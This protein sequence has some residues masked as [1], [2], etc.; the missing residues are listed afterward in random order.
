MIYRVIGVRSG[1]SPDRFQIVFTEFT[2]TGGKWNYD[3]V[4]EQQFTH[5]QHWKEQLKSAGDISVLAYQL[6][7]I[8]YGKYI[9]EKINL[10]IREHALEHKV[11]LVASDGYTVFNLPAQGLSAEIGHCKEMFPGGRRDV[12]GRI[13]NCTDGCTQVARRS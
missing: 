3:N 1:H 2:E 9:G 4:I 13:C 10:F 11:H 8:S 6:L 12:F 5:D 7:H